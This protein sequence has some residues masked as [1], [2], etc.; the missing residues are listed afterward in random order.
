MACYYC[1]CKLTF[2]LTICAVPIPQILR[3]AE[4]FVSGSVGMLVGAIASNEEAALA[5][6][7][8]LMTVAM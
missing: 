3:Q 7:P 8:V 5:L 6:G 1:L 2:A 4:S